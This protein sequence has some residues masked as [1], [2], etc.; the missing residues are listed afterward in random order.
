M[1][2]SINRVES[3]DLDTAESDNRRLVLPSIVVKC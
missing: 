2:A 3:N 1:E